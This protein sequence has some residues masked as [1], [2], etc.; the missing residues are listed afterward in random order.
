MERDLLA[1][2][3]RNANKIS[4]ATLKHLAGIV[5]D[6]TGDWYQFAEGL[7]KTA[8]IIDAMER[9]G[10]SEGDAALEAQKWLF[11]YSLIGPS[12]RYLRNAPVGIPFLTFHLKALP[13]MLEVARTAPWRFAPYVALPYVLTSMVAGMADVDDDDVKA[14]QKALPDWLQSRG[15]AYV[16]P[17]KDDSGRWQAMD[18]GYFL[19]WTMWTS[20][21]SE[22]AKGDIGDAMMT[23]GVL[24]GPLPDLIAAIQTNRDP[25]TGRDIINEADPPG[26]QIVSMLSYLYGM[27]MPT[28]LTNYG[29]VGHLLRAGEGEVDRYGLPKTGYGQAAARLVGVNLYPI[30]PET[31]R[32]DN[33]RRMRFEIGEISRRMR[34]QLRNPNLSAEDR[35]SVRDEYLE[36]IRARM[37]QMAKYGAESKVHPNLRRE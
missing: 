5:M 20:L 22:T 23:S 32:S 3:A 30:D 24:G 18:F 8:K 19:P 26:R 35:S 25:F 7:F 2:E 10:K 31:S 21:V 37:E 17:I 33:L 36:L 14:L 9:Q 12:T 29:A 4:M 34:Q 6:K 16:L 11:D 13:R 27:A 28:W 1:L 15:H